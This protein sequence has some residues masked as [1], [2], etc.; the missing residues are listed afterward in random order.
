M[1]Y[2]S[3]IIYRR[4]ILVKIVSSSYNPEQAVAEA[5]AAVDEAERLHEANGERN[6]DRLRAAQTR[7]WVAERAE[8]RYGHSVPD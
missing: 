8:G 5:K 1:V 7:L 6:L 4:R 3:L 2:F